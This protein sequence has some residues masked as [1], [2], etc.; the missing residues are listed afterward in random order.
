MAEVEG[1]VAVI[2]RAKM[3]TAVVNTLLFDAPGN[4]GGVERRPIVGGVE[5][6]R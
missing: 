1:T 6:L 3:T 5:Q 4:G 2:E